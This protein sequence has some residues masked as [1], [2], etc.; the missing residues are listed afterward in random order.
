M[1]VLLPATG[2]VDHLF[3]HSWIWLKLLLS[4]IKVPYFGQ[5]K[6]V[7]C[8]DHRTEALTNIRPSTATLQPDTNE[9]SGSTSLLAQ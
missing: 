5:R 9:R 4:A 8:P 6:A 2:P 7:T 1:K 3:H